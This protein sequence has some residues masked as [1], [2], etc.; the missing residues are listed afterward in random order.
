MG[1][2]QTTN[3]GQVKKG[4]VVQWGGLLVTIPYGY[5]LCDGTNGTRDLRNLF[6]VGG[7]ADFG[8]LPGS[9]IEG[10]A[11]NFGGANNH[12]HSLIFDV[13]AGHNVMAGV[14]D[15]VA[16]NPVSID[17]NVDPS[18]ILPP[19]MVMYYIQKL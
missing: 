13:D 11:S 19:Y 4:T 18:Y 2:S 3:T 10:G 16:A 17:T 8:G 9:T 12:D 5:H 1:L 14:T 6:I 15:T 7:N